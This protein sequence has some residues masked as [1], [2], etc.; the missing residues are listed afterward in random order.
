[1]NPA[2]NRSL[3]FLSLYLF[4]CGNLFAQKNEL[5]HL[6]EYGRLLIGNNQP[7][8]AVLVADSTIAIAKA[9]KQTY[10]EIRAMNVKANAL[11]YLHQTKEAIALYFDALRL[12]KK[13]D[14][15]SQ[16][17]FI[18][19]E[20]GYLY[21]NQQDFVAAKKYFRQELEVRREMKDE[22][23]YG[24]QLINLASIHRALGE[25][26]SAKVLLDEVAKVLAKRNDTILD[27][28][29]YNEKGTFFQSTEQVDSARIYYLK[30]EALWKASNNRNQ[31]L[32]V[33]FNL[34]ELE[35]AQKNY[36]VALAYYLQSDSLA[37]LGNQPNE[38]VVIEKGIAKAFAANGDYEKAYLFSQQA[39]H[40][41]DSLDKTQERATI[42][43]L[44]RQSN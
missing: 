40:I 20:L 37:L 16:I 19:N 39:S 27:G 9:Q 43:Q 25:Y 14:D 18:N 23:R 41:S 30:A 22:K 36:A 31:L 32:R 1:V 11:T 21:F 3:L 4:S 33:L 24:H 44:D 35:L 17:A 38:Q 29:Y 15:N 2:I 10:Y 28:A 12:C 26:D 5:D 34:G 8:S 7:D 6:I 42:E 13:P